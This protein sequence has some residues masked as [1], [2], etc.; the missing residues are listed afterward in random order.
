MRPDLILPSDNGLLNE[1]N[2]YPLQT[3]LDFR[4][5]NLTFGYRAISFFLT[6]CQIGLASL[7]GFCS[8]GS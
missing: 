7:V 8:R 6:V 1:S 2:K 3:N 4:I 5:G